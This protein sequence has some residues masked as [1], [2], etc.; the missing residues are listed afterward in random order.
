MT[1]TKQ[2]QLF[3]VLS[4]IE[5]QLEHVRFLINDSVPTSDWIDTK[6][7]SNRSTLNNKTVT[8]YVGKGVIKKAKKLMED[9]SFMFRSWNI[10]A[11]R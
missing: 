4:G 9:I 5:S 11:S 6:E 1:Q 3:K 2:Q 7:F 10:G 8:N